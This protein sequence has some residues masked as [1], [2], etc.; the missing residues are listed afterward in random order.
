MKFK[1]QSL[2]NETGNINIDNK[3]RFSQEMG[4]NVKV[5][6]LQTGLSIYTNYSYEFS[7]DD[8]WKIGAGISYIL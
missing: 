5:G 6:E 2:G 8:S 4:I 7:K 3:N 1:V